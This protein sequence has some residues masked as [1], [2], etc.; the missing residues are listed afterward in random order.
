MNTAPLHDDTFP[1]LMVPGHHSGLNEIGRRQASSGDASFYVQVPARPKNPNGPRWRVELHF[2]D[3]S[4]MPL[5]LEIADAAILGRGHTADIPL[6]Q[7]DT[8]GLGI[9]RQHAMVRPSQRALFFFD[10]E[11]TN[12]THHNGIPV[13]S[14]TANTLALNDVI[15]LGRLSLTVRLIERVS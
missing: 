15:R 8:G 1:T 4:L 14:G 5:R 12:G 2:E 3:T 10:L 13:G 9:S 6:D 7:Y 11:S